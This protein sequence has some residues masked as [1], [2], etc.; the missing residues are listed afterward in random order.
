MSLVMCVEAARCFLFSQKSEKESKYEL[1]YVCGGRLDAFL[2][3]KKV[4]RKAN[5]KGKQHS[6]EQN[7]KV[8]IPNYIIK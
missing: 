5:H 6:K 7:Q 2:L 4:K 3:A 8:R 1:A